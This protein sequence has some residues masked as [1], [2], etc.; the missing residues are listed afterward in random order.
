MNPDPRAAVARADQEP[1]NRLTTGRRATSRAARLAK[2]LFW[3]AAGVGAAEQQHHGE[4]R[5]AV[6]RG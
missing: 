4:Q 1:S 6:E 5:E 2:T 3:L